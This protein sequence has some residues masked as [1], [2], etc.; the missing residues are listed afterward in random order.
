MVT[1]FVAELPLVIAPPLGRD[2]CAHDRQVAVGLEDDQ[3]DVAEPRETMLP[4][5]RAQLAL[6]DGL[7]LKGVPPR[8]PMIEQDAGSPLEQ[9]ADPGAAEGEPD[10]QVIR[11]E[12]LA[13]PM[14]PPVSELSFPIIAF[15]STFETSSRT[16]RSS[17]FI[18][19]SSRLPPSRRAITR[20][21]KTSRARKTFSSTETFRSKRSET[22][23]GDEES[24]T[25]TASPSPQQCAFLQATE[26]GMRAIGGVAAHRSCLPL[27]R[28]AAGIDHGRRQAS[29]EI[30][31]ASVIG[32]RTSRARRDR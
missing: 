31:L 15:W 24:T 7:A 20:K 17:T 10:E 27:P 8:L 21:P 23:E 1:R 11:A 29:P 2:V 14:A 4:R 18:C 28:L 3:L 5:R 22:S 9:A 13:A 25:A 16:A 30:P 6:R 32:D 12:Q 19:P 26:A